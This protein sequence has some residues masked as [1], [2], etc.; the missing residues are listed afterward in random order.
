MG[1]V[2]LQTVCGHVRVCDPDLRRE[3]AESVVR[4]H[5]RQ[6]IER[7]HPG[8]RNQKSSLST[9]RTYEMFQKVATHERHHLL[10]FLNLRFFK[11]T[12]YFIDATTVLIYG[13]LE[14]NR[15]K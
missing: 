15:S 13:Y 1:R 4:I 8:S 9:R 2:L 11:A 3:R 6:K 7:Q 14:T 10:I 12:C 5:G